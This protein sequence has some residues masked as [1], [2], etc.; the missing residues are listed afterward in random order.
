MNIPEIK[1]ICSSKELLGKH[2]KLRL[3]DRSPNTYKYADVEYAE[4]AVLIPVFFKNGEANILLT[5]RTDKVE[6]HKPF[7]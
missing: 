1:K 2:L 4:A 5:K 6:H 7:G 3:S